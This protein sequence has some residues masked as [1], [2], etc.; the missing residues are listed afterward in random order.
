MPPGSPGRSYRQ[1]SQEVRRER[2]IARSYG[3]KADP[4]DSLPF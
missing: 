1:E 4:D 3:L 2:A